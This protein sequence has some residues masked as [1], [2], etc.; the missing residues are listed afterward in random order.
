[1]LEPVQGWISILVYSQLTL[2]KFL[3]LS[4][5]QFSSLVNNIYSWLKEL[6]EEKRM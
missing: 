3:S 5:L 2:G 1:M 4:M 6:H